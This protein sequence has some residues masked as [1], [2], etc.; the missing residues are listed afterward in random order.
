[1]EVKVAIDCMGGD[2]GVRVTVP[3][4]LNVL[5]SDPEVSFLLVGRQ[6]AV[7]QQLARHGSAA[8]GRAITTTSTSPSNR[9]RSWRNQSR[10]TRRIRLRT[11]ADPTS[12]IRSSVGTNSC[13]WTRVLSP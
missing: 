8:G 6:D 13:V 3:A 7:E 9:S 1:M 11:T 5:K 2:H 12:R 10:T 4:A